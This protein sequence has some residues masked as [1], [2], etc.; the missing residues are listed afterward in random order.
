METGAF[1]ANIRT[2]VAAAASGF[3][4]W[5][6]RYR[7][8]T[9]SGATVLVVLLIIWARLGFTLDVSRFYAAEPPSFVINSA[10]PLKHGE[11]L[12]VS[13]SATNAS[14]C[15]PQGWF[16]T[17]GRNEGTAESAPIDA[18]VASATNQVG[19][20]CTYANGDTGTAVRSFLV[21][22]ST[23]PTT[24]PPA[25]APGDF[26]G[27]KP[28]PAELRSYASTQGWSED[29]VR[30]SDAVLQDWIDCCWN[31]QA[32]KFNSRRE[33]VAGLW[34]KPT[35]CPAGMVPGGPNETDPCITQGAPV[36]SPPPSG[37]L[38]VQCGTGQNVLTWGPHPQ[39]NSNS[40]ERGNT[41]T[42]NLPEC[43]DYWCWLPSSAYTHQ[44]P[45]AQQPATYT[46]TQIQQ[47][48]CYGYRVKYAPAIP[49]NVVYCPSGC[50]AS[51]TPTVTPTPTATPTP[52]PLACAPQSQEVSAGAFATFTATGGSGEYS[53]VIQGENG[54]QTDSGDTLTFNAGI[55]GSYQIAL[56]DG[57]TT[58]TCAL[59][60]NA[61]PPPA[62][63]LTLNAAVRNVTNGGSFGATTSARPGQQLQ[64]RLIVQAVGSVPNVIV[65]AVLPDTLSYVP[66]STTVDGVPTSVDSVVTGGLGLG[67]MN[68]RQHTIIFGVNVK[69]AGQLPS[70]TLTSVIP[71]EADGDG[72]DA[73]GGS[74]VVVIDNA[75]VVIRDAGGTPTGPGESTVLALLAGA[76]L[77]LLYVSYAH[78]HA[79]R[80]R[81]AESLAKRRDPMD[82]VS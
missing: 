49:S 12:S 6:R 62:A 45:T 7:T 66:S 67:S 18:C 51:P 76:L 28:T 44:A 47:G 70:G 29:F 55:P 21:D 10:Q 20:R 31:V 13:W 25:P 3:L 17:Q 68:A 77:T 46:D 50:N 65:R 57:S 54:T 64:V 11:R 38:Q 41:G 43:A 52:G 26:T 14:S 2:R 36:A 4:A 8:W 60:V 58:V 63:D 59:T 33:G 23:C 9:L 79:F 1:I 19:I 81:E 82:F 27:R 73:A 24:A 32:K 48:T 56:A 75:G 42:K 69:N 22:K 16:S 53:W 80:S 61:G 71:A 37:T 40:I 5:I 74:A 35:E 34:E 78:S 72:V 39:A 15:T 30:F